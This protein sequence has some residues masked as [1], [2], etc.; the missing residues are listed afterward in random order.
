MNSSVRTISG[1]EANAGYFT[2]YQ[3]S[4]CLDSSL[5]ETKAKGKI[6]VCRY[7]GSSS[8]SRMGKSLVVKEAGGVGMILIDETEQG[9]ASPFAIPAVSV[10]RAVGEKIL[11]YVNSTRFC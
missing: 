6:L 3:S 7:S 11:S 8:E 2:P 5:N 9:I 4:F 10:G 1:S